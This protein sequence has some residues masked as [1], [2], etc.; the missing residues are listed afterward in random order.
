M[1][2]AVGLALIFLAPLA[3]FYVT[4]RVRKLPLDLYSR[5]VSDGTGTYLDPGKGFVDVGPVHLRDIRIVKGDVSA[6]SRGVAVWDSFDSTFDVQNHHELSYAIERYTLDRRT[7][8]SVRCCGENLDRGGALSLTFP[9]GAGKQSYPWWDGTAKA[10]F[11]MRY[12]GTVKLFGLSLYHYRQTIEPTIINHLTLPG[13][14]IGEPEA[15]LVRLD[16]WYRADTD[17]LVEPTTGAPVRGTQS[18]DQWLADSTGAR[19]LTVA[20]TRFAQSPATVKTLV[21]YANGLRKQLLLVQSFLPA[22]G[23]IIGLVLLAFGLLLLLR[24]AAPAGLA[25]A[26]AGGQAVISGNGA[27]AAEARRGAPAQSAATIIEETSDTG[28]SA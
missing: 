24:S 28:P 11:P 25:V 17:V 14:T 4:P 15:G 10:A 13:T 3:K 8:Q 21:D 20:T 19:K 5:N 9:L 1:L 12:A 16:W 6:G 2:V 22:F 23:W 18:A 26:P 27:A 7:G